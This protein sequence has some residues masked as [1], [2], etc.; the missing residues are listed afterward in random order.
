M[1]FSFFDE[2]FQTET[3]GGSRN[4]QTGAP[5][6]KGVQQSII[7]PNFP[8]K[9][10]EKWKN[11]N[12]KGRGA[13][14]WHLSWIHQCNEL[15]RHLSAMLWS[16]TQTRC[17]KWVLSPWRPQLNGVGYH[18]ATQT[19]HNV[20]VQLLTNGIPRS[21]RINQPQ[22]PHTPYYCLIRYRSN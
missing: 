2:I 22:G 6:P 19:T 16:Q 17:V 15:P 11:L 20:H 10:R 5:T 18:Q 21:N 12:Q 13:R 4:S 14:P 9:L 7:W 1:E 3:S 8:R